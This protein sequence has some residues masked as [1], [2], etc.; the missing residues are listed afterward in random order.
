MREPQIWI[1]SVCKRTL[2]LRM[3]DEGMRLQ[4]TMQDS[5]NADHEPQPIQA[6][7]TWKARC[8][9]CSVDEVTHR[10][11]ARDFEV[12]YLANHESS[13]DWA[14]C[15]GCAELIAAGTWMRLV[16]RVVYMEETK[17]G[18][19]MTPVAQ[20]SLKIL[21][22]S[23]RQAISGPIEPISKENESISKENE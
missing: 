16:E 13:G 14:A 3:D 2:D 9:F 1:C 7:D 11:P 22:L 23:L 15:S 19:P 4:H 18:V 21:Y 10:L 17:R 20:R 12:P 8:D 5:R 6:D